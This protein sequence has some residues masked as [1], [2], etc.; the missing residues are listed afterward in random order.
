MLDWM[1]RLGA[2]R[3]FA[4]GFALLASFGAGAAWAAQEPAMPTG[5]IGSPAGTQ[6]RVGSRTDPAAV[7]VNRALQ[8]R[9]DRSGQRWVCTSS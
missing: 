4:L 6:G 7:V 1:A 5:P 8:R 3:Q 9:V 2:G